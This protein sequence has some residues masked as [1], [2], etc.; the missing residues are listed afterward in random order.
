MAKNML[1]MKFTPTVI[2]ADTGSTA[3]SN[4]KRFRGELRTTHTLAGTYVLREVIVGTGGGA[5]WTGTGELLMQSDI[6]SARSY[7]TSST[8]DRIFVDKF[9][10]SGCGT[11]VIPFQTSTSG[12]G[13]PKYW[14]RQTFGSASVTMD[15]ELARHNVIHLGISKLD[16]NDYQ[17]FTSSDLEITLL[18]QEV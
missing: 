16:T 7:L 14:H 1:I 13:A 6:F 3:N 8:T 12:G 2:D 4:T 15:I 18:W 17:N 11:L 9:C 5:T 10:G